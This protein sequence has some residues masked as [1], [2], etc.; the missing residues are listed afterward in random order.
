M[1]TKEVKAL[2]SNINK[3]TRETRRAEQD[4]DTCAREHG[5]AKRRLADLQ[6]ECEQVAKTCVGIRDI[7]VHM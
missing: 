2:Q 3:N 1:L 5:E 6:A 4:R 7:C